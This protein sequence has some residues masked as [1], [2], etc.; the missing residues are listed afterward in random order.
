MQKRECIY[1]PVFAVLTGVCGAVFRAVELHRAF[2]MSTG[3]MTPGDRSVLIMRLFTVVVIILSAILSALLKGKLAD[4]LHLL[5][6]D[7]N[8]ASKTFSIAGSFLL[9]IAAAYDYMKGRQMLLTSELVLLLLAVFAAISL[10][11]RITKPG[12]DYAFFSIVPVFWCCFWLILMY[13]DRSIDPVIEYYIYELFAVVTGTLFFYRLAGYEFGSRKSRLSVFFGLITIYLC[14]VTA[15]GPIIAKIIY[16]HPIDHDR[17]LLYFASCGLIALG[18][19][20][21]LTK[22]TSRNQDSSQSAA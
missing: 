1:L 17:S 5:S 21:W 22:S 13:R 19:S 2:D 9:I 8:T 3:L 18:G 12:K 4:G 11:V 14:L 16:D 15:L 7:D 6:G 20:C 10:I